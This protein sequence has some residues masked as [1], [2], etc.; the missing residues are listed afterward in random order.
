MGN[1]VDELLPWA[2]GVLRWEAVA[3]DS[4]A[5]FS[6]FESARNGN[7]RAIARLAEA[8]KYDAAAHVWM[9]EVV[10]QQMLDSGMSETS[11][12]FAFETLLMR[13]PK[14]KR[15]QRKVAANFIREEAFN[16]AKELA[17][18]HEDLV[19]YDKSGVRVDSA[20]DVVAEALSRAFG[21]KTQNPVYWQFK[22]SWIAEAKRKKG[23]IT[24]L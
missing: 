23:A 19:F 24:R 12:K 6:E 9:S 20:C 22:A 18:E 14:G 3:P 1:L 7:E 5:T 2:E 10:A 16:K 15:G 17:N 13:K 11:V 4:L 8:A 21:D